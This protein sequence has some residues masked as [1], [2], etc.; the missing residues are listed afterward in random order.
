MRGPAPQGVHPTSLLRGT[1]AAGLGNA[2]Q[3][4]AFRWL[5]RTGFLARALTYGLIGALT[6]ALA[7]GAGT[8]RTAPDQQGALRLIAQA[9]LGFAAL[10]VIAAGLL[11]YAAWKLT[12]AL[13]GRGPEGGGGQ[14]ASE[15]LANAGGGIGY[16]VFAAGVMQIL[17][18]SG[19]DSGGSPSHAAAGVMGWPAGRWLV[20]AAGIALIAG[21]VYQAYYALTD[22]FTKQAKTEQMSPRERSLHRATGRVGLVARAVVFGLCGYFLTETAISYN[23]SNAVGIGGALLRLHHQTFGPWIVD[24]VGIGLLVFAAFSLYEARYRRL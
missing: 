20:G 16:L 8:G 22:G 6:L 13:R 9:P 12:Q 7:T 19:G 14:K 5:V 4:P 11:A 3:A 17:V 1:T 18:S 10:A 23:P 21:S 2:E 24:L 15:R